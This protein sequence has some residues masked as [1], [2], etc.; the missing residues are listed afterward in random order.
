MPTFA[1]KL[2]E[3]RKA[4]DFTQDRLSKEMNVSRQTISHWEN[5]RAIPDIDAIKHLSQVLDYNFLAVEGMTEE[6]QP[7]PEAEE[8]PAQ[9]EEHTAQ[10][11]A[12][13]QRSSTPRKRRFVLPAV[14]GAVLLCAILFVCLLMNGKPSGEPANLYEPYSREWYQQEQT[15]VA[16]QAFV[17]IKARENPVYAVKDESVPDGAM[18]FYEFQIQEQ[19]GIAFTIEEAVL[20]TFRTNGTTAREVFTSDEITGFFGTCVLDDDHTIPW[21]G[22]FPIQNVSGMGMLITGTDEKGNHLE[23]HGYVELLQ[24]IREN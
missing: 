8:I 10:E 23:F 14:L 12:V 7:A 17:R 16:D 15:P 9:P 18:W 21:G 19:N 6:T 1:E 13:Q 11:T 3:V 4:R 5:G 2:Q 22:G 20:T 24:E